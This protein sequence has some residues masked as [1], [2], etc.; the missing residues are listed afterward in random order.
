M[1]GYGFERPEDFDFKSY[2]DFMASY[3][4][5][6][7]RRAQRWKTTVGDKTT[8]HLAKTNKS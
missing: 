6:L 7:A 1:D 3:L 4:S 5:V 2:E 8:S